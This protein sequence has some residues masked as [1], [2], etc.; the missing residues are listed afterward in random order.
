MVGLV[1]GIRSGTS[2]RSIMGVLHPRP[3]PNP[4]HTVHRVSA[5]IVGGFLLVFGILGLSRG[6]ALLAPPGSVV[7][8][9]T[10]NGLLSI[11]SVV[12]GVALV[13]AAVRGGPTA[14]TVSVVV[15]TGFL[16]SGLVNVFLL[17]SPMNM[18][19]FTLP[20]VL[21][22]FA[23]GGVLLVLG[24]YGRISGRLPADSPYASGEVE[25]VQDPDAPRDRADAAA[26]AELAEAERARARHSATPEQVD[27]LR[28]VDRERSS[29]DRRRV[30]TAQRHE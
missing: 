13:G 8:G 15:G 18:L 16:V 3:G 17:T 29:E 7:M 19:A 2:R 6:L 27:R 25:Q 1:A 5:A 20:N 22:S 12:V 28:G 10:T 26:A 9:L 30:W 14:S 24:A 4:V 23:V 11:V 21:F